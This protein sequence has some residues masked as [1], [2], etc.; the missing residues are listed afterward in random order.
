M[1]TPKKIPHVLL[2]IE[3]TRSYSRDLLRGV[4]RYLAEHGPW[5]VYMDMR[6][7]ESEAPPWLRSWRGDGIITR[8]GSKAVAKAVAAAKVPTVEL[9]ATT[10]GVNFPFL[11]VDNSAMGTM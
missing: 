3:T 2:L 8:T 10:L 7:L 5:S 1:M 11:G 6:A 9:R 4:R